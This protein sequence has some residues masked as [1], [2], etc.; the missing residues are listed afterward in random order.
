MEDDASS[1]FRRLARLRNGRKAADKLKVA[2]IN[3]S[4]GDAIL[5][6]AIEALRP[7]SET[8]AIL[9]D[10]LV[11]TST[12]TELAQQV[13]NINAELAELNQKKRIAT[14]DDMRRYEKQIDDLVSDRKDIQKDIEDNKKEIE[15]KNK[16]IV[17]CE[18]V[19]KT[20]KDIEDLAGDWHTTSRKNEKV[21][22]IL[23]QFPDFDASLSRFFIGQVPWSH[24]IRPLIVSIVVALTY[25]ILFSFNLLIF[26]QLYNEKLIFPLMELPE[27]IVGLD[28]GQT[29]PKD[30]IP[31]V[32]KNYS[33]LGW[34]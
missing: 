24:W 16:E 4:Q 32:Y 27:V 22:E 6:E 14:L 3:E 5:L 34:F 30:I 23:A 33:V 31:A 9:D 7:C 21:D 28:E 11:L 1:Y 25:L 29:G 19:S 2:K 8:K 18:R 26:R 20:M 10:I 12:D 17:I 15:R 13:A